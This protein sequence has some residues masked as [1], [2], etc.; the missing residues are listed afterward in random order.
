MARLNANPNA[1]ASVEFEVVA[2]G[3]YRMRVESIE[4]FVAQSGST[5]WRTRMTYVDPS[6][7]TKEDGTPCSNAGGI[8]D[9]GLVASPAEKQGKLRSFVE[10]CGMAW[11]DLDSEDLIG[12][13]L[14]VKVGTDEWQGNRKNVASRYLKPQLAGSM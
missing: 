5:C 12:C 11:A 7:L 2:P 6:S 14:D 1:E 9:S 10:A 3:V 8:I 13:E 4:E